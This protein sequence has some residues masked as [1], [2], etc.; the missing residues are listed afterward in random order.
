[1]IRLS[2]FLLFFLLLSDLTGQD[3]LRL[4]Q[5]TFIALQNVQE[6]EMDPLGNLY[7]LSS[8]GAIEKYD[9][10][11]SK[12]TVFT[13]NRLGNPSAIFAR[14]ALKVFV[15]YP[16][17]RTIVVL[18]RNLVQL[19]GALN[20]IELGFQNAIVL[21]PSVDG[22][23]WLYDEVRFK[24]L[25]ISPDGT[26]LAESQGLDLLLQRRISIQ[27]L[28]DNGQQAIAYDPLAGLLFFDLFGQFKRQILTDQSIEQLQLTGSQLQWLDSANRLV[29]MSVGF[30]TVE[31]S[32]VLPKT[33]EAARKKL[34]ANGFIT[35]DPKGVQVW[36]R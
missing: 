35:W 32:W 36:N 13:Q 31:K 15:W 12:R 26:L 34:V 3:T 17:F 6:V 11:G 1:M 4:V 28:V 30:P 23:I 33:L 29:E 20:L 27:I 22:N 10:S 14:N 9:G 8:K 16:D 24:L 21:G 18:D 2:T 25:K 19:G 5:G 7:V